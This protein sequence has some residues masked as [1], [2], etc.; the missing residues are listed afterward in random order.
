M[1]IIKGNLIDL[2]EAGEFDVIVH[3]C[4]CFN[5]MGSGIAREIRERYPE[6]YEADAATEKGDKNKLG[7]YTSYNTGKFTIVNAYT[8]YTF[9]LPTDQFEY[10]AFQLLLN[11]LAIDFPDS[12]FG[13]PLIGCGLA[14]GNKQKIID[15]IDG[16]GIVLLFQGGEV[17]IVEFNGETK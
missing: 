7:T 12:R 16:F 6:A 14:G 15:M 1:R 8:Q 13:F 17:T 11:N 9:W 3:G 2:A 5:T 10:D 4:N